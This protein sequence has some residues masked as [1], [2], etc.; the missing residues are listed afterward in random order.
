MSSRATSRYERKF[1]AGATDGRDVELVVRG[2]PAL[3]QEEY[4]PRY[5]NNIYLDTPDRRAYRDH[6]DGVGDRQKHRIRWYGA[7]SGLLESPV[8]ERKAKR[9]LVGCKWS[10]HLPAFRFCRSFDYGA[11]IAK[12]G[13][14]LP[15]EIWALLQS[16]SPSIV[17]RYRRRYYRS[18]DG[19]FRLTAD[20][21]LTFGAPPPHGDP[22]SILPWREPGT[23]LELKYAVQDEDRAHAVT[24]VLPFRVTRW[25]KYC[26][27]VE[28]VWRMR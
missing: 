20:D 13:L 8:L 10:Y 17:N 2:H 4:P 25:S 27:G 16:C 15:G 9:G 1:F 24:S 12:A 6:V 26:H 18:A 11:F 7:L 14:D 22:G 28:A 21:Q 5:I 3:F 23:I 19:A